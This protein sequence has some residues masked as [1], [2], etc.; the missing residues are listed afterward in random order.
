MQ[1]SMLPPRVHSSSGAVASHIYNHLSDNTR[2]ALQCR[3]GG[4][5]SHATT[6]LQSD[7]RAFGCKICAALAARPPHAERRAAFALWQDST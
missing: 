3:V 2:L 5:A 6:A 1:Q 4:M 7:T